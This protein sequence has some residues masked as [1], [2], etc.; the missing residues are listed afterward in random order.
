MN[1]TSTNG[2]FQSQAVSLSQSSKDV[3]ATNS[4]KLEV[5]PERPSSATSDQFESKGISAML[6]KDAVVKA[7]KAQNAD[8]YTNASQ[9]KVGVR[10]SIINI[11]A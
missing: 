6:I 5:K 4:S 9:P 8:F 3:M 11:S 1:V 2:N 10:G 7:Q